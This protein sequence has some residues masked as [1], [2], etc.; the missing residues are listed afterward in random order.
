MSY[1]PAWPNTARMPATFTTV[2]HISC[3][4]VTSEEG[5]E[6]EESKLLGEAWDALEKLGFTVSERSTSIDFK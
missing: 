5:C 6:D 3:D 4:T 2:L 1:D